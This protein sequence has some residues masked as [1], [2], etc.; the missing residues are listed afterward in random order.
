MGEEIKITIRKIRE[1]T[2]VTREKMGKLKKELEGM[3]RINEKT[4][5][6]KCKN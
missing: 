6:K 5:K 3:R 4:E 1:D 2:K